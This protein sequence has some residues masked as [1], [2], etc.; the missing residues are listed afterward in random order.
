MAS[1]WLTLVL[2][3]R[4]RRRRHLHGVLVGQVDELALNKRG[5]SSE[6]LTVQVMNE[7][8]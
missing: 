1:R 8:G 6:A 5:P 7:A 3:K 2:N 4:W